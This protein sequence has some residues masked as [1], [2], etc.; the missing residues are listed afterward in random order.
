MRKILFLLVLVFT[1]VGIAFSHEENHEKRDKMFREVQEF[2]MKYLAQEMDLSEV[3]KKKF[4]ELYEEM[5]KSKKECYHDAVE[6]DRKLKEEKNPTDQEYQQ[7]RNAFNESN[8]KWSDI[9]KQYDDKFSEFLTQ[10]QMYKMKEA[11]QSF[12]TK[13]EEM[14]L[15]RKKNRE[16]HKRD[17]SDNKK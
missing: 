3:Q 6:M 17:K 5:C 16:P 2:K 13:L 11:E 8:T 15:N 12:R 7:V 4:F 14:K 1:S 10:K 9:E